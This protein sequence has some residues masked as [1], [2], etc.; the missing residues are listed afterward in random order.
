MAFAA[1]SLFSGNSPE[2]VQ[3]VKQGT[4]APEGAGIVL[5]INDIDLEKPTFMP[6]TLSYSHQQVIEKIRALFI[7]DDKEKISYYFD[8]AENRLSEIN[9]ATKDAKPKLTRVS[10]KKA[11]NIYEK[12]YNILK[13]RDSKILSSGDLKTISDHMSILTILE[14]ESANSDLKDGFEEA[15]KYLLLIQ[16]EN[17]RLTQRLPRT[18]FILVRGSS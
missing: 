5:G 7:C 11:A 16:S 3:K 9:Q 6:Y 4:G 2:V 12:S 18:K 8:L 10:L 13:D 15:L 1:P 17:D 14:E